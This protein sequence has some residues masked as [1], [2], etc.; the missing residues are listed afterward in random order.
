MTLFVVLQALFNLGRCWWVS[1]YNSYDCACG[2]FNH[3]DLFIY[4]LFSFPGRAL[5]YLWI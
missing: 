2:D 4:L 1:Y 3:N 5:P